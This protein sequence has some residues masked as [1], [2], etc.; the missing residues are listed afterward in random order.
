MSIRYLLKGKKNL[1]E[2]QVIIGNIVNKTGNTSYVIKDSKGR[3]FS[4]E[5]SPDYIIG[6]TVSI[7]KGIIVG[8]TKSLKS[9]KEFTV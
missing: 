2:D 4:V 1:I 8:R 7:K 9:F 6:Q 3:G 5:G